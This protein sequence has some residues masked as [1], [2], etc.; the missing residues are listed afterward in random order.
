MSYEGL[1]E[2]VELVYDNEEEVE[3]ENGNYDYV[4]HARTA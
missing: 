2:M 3:W 1:E 4:R